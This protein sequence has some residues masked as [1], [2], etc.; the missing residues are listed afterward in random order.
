MGLFSRNKKVEVEQVSN[1]GDGDIQIHT[2]YDGTIIEPEL[3]ESKK[4]LISVAENIPLELWKHSIID[5]YHVA[6]DIGMI[7]LDALKVRFIPLVQNVNIEHAKNSE[8]LVE[9]FYSLQEKF[10]ENR[11]KLTLVALH[12]FQNIPLNP[13]PNGKKATPK[14]DTRKA[15]A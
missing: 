13:S 8:K 12:E 3:D 10:I 1:V 2:D 15:S 14:K 5:G 11:R 9:T 4:L 7:K 6:N